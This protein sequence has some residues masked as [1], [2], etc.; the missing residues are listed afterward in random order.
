MYDQDVR[1][2]CGQGCESLAHPDLLCRQIQELVV[3]ISSRHLGCQN[4]P[5]TLYNDGT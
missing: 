4:K 2:G 5:F 1:S 3:Y